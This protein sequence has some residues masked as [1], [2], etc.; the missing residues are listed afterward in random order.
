MS[1]API[2]FSKEPLTGTDGP[3]SRWMIPPKKEGWDGLVLMEWELRAESWTDEHVH[4]E[5]AYV[6]EG[7]LFVEVDGTVVEATEGDTVQVPAGA[8]GTYYAPEYARLIGI[9]A[10]NPTGAP[11]TNAQ[12][13]KL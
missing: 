3:K 11:M 9:Y 1:Y 4:D 6:L 2:K 10:P 13:K 8:I 7:K 12:Y 5:F